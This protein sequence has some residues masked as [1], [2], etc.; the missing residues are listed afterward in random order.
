MAV[1]QTLSLTQKT[2]S[3][4]SNYSVVRLLWQS[5]QSGDSYNG[6]TK[7]AYYYV[8][9]NGGAEERYSV[10][11]TLPKNSTKAIADVEIIVPHNADGTGSV[12]VRTWMDTGLYDGVIEKTQTL[13]LT[14]IPR[15]SSMAVGNGTLGVAQ[16]ISVTRQAN[17]FTH[18]ITYKCGGTSGRICTKSSSTSISWTPPLD[19]AY[20]AP[21]GTTVPVTFTIQTFSGENS[22]GTETATATYAIPES[23]FPPVAFAATDLTACYGKYGAYVQGKSKLKI[24]ITTYGVYG[25]WIKS[26]KTE[27]DGKVYTTETVETEPLSQSGTL[28]IKVTVTDSRNRVTVDS[29]TITVLPYANPNVSA[30]TVCR[31]DANGNPNSKGAYILAQFTAAVSPLNSKNTARYYIG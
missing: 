17:S 3:I 21:Q 12:R 27:I 24:D 22:I 26:C 19:L 18:S 8:S 10:S 6:Y 20:Q 30:F 1:T 15:R 5:T 11:Y 7:T 28:T 25:S 4:V 9:K 13:S 14:T 31:S 16:N 29:S 2:Q 23:L